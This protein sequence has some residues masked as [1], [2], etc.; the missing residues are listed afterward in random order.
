MITRITRG[1]LRPN[2]EGRVFEMLRQASSARPLVPGLV[3][4]SLSRTVDGHDTVLVAVTVWTD[5]DAMAAVLGPSWQEP[6]WMPGLG[7]LVAEATVEI[8]ETVATSAQD[9]SELAPTG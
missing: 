5:V 1:K 2:T 8:L 4:M 3:N 7:E 6:S 9:L